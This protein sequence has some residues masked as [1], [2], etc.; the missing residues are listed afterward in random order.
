M[1]SGKPTIDDLVS[2]VET[3]QIRRVEEA[4]AF[5]ARGFRQFCELMNYET[6]RLISMTHKEDPDF[7]SAMQE[8][9]T[10]AM[11]QT[12]KR[13]KLFADKQDMTNL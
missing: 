2:V 5:S 7:W 10:N 1:T 11:T 9:A 13:A 3:W 8:L 6:R 4:A 12:T